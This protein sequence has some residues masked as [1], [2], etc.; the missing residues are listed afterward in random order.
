MISTIKA[1]IKKDIQIEADGQPIVHRFEWVH[2][3]TSR[4]KE[5]IIKEKEEF[6]KSESQNS[7]SKQFMD[8]R[9]K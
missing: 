8:V 7:Q 2:N 9:S 3:V 4:I 6:V 1:E 5:N